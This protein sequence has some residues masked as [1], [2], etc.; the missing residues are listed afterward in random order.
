M[1]PTVRIDTRDFVRQM[2]GFTQQI[3]FAVSVALNATAKEAVGFVRSNLTGTFVIR[4]KW[5]AS[6]V[7]FNP[8]S[9]RNLSVEIGSRQPYM[10]AQA[11]G[12]KKTPT[13]GKTVGI[14]QVGPGRVRRTIKTPT[15][16]G[17]F[18]GA[19][20]KKPGIFIAS[21]RFP[22]SPGVWQRLRSGRL[23][24]LYSLQPSVTVK[25]RWDLAGQVG[26]VVR[27]RFPDN[28]V[29]AM[30]RALQTARRS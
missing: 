4:S 29:R 17:K 2:R 23:R 8:S 19:L 14:P 10:E 12:G 25:P 20:A 24:L 3:P 26:Q 16:P 9:K 30:E 5:V 22:E 15:R 11:V 18:P 28:A 1:T 21:V 7:T 27:D 6:G 13:K